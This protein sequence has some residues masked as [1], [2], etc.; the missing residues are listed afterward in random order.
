MSH[1]SRK[2]GIAVAALGVCLGAKAFASDHADGLATAVDFAA[3]ITDVYV[4]ASPR[5][6]NK[7][8]LIMNVHPFASSG[9]KFS[10]AVDYKIRI[11]PIDDKSTMRPSSDPHR[12]KSIVCNF[13]G[14]DLFDATQTATC[15]FDLSGGR[16]IVSFPTRRPGY[17]AG[18]E[19]TADGI[20]VFAGVRSDPWFLDLGKVVKINFG[21]RMGDGAG[22]NGLD[23]TNVLSIVAEVDKSKMPGTLIAVAGQTVRK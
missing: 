14:G 1:F 2:L 21:L 15:T 10:D 9:S 6:A 11:R 20:R 7:V 22:S 18:G 23:G 17:R 4:F 8:V 13:A 3:D 19:G 16:E 12:E 5:D